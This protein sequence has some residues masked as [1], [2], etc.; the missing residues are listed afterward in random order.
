MITFNLFLQLE[1]SLIIF[2]ELIHV[3]IFF[4][5]TK[6]DYIARY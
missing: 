5:F 6:D 3:P 4:F 1:Y 2:I